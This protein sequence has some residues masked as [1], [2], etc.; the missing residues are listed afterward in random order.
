MA[1][2]HETKIL[3]VSV[4]TC[5]LG[6]LNLYGN[7]SNIWSWRLCFWRGFDKVMK[8]IYLCLFQYIPYY[9]CE[10]DGSNILKIYTTYFSCSPNWLATD[11]FGLFYNC[12]LMIFGFI[13]PT[14]IIAV[15]N[16]CVLLKSHRVSTYR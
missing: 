8:S 11:A 12:Y 13:I 16:V 15:S 5:N 7:T 14:I 10:I 9:I 2:G 4:R 1:L 3:C 6:I